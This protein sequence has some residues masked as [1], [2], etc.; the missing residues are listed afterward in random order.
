MSRGCKPYYIIQYTISLYLMLLTNSINS[1]G[2]SKTGFEIKG[3]ITNAEGKTIFIAPTAQAIAIDSAI[4]RNGTFTLK[5]N[6]KEPAYFALLL[7][8]QQA[9]TWFILSKAKLVFTGN[10]DSMRQASIT[11]SK[12]LK[13]AQKLRVIIKPYFASQSASFDSAFAAY[14]RGDTATGIKFEELNVAI[15]KSI[16]DSIANFIKEHPNSYISLAQLNELYKIY[17]VEKSKK[18]FIELSP[19]LQKQS[20][21]KQ[22]KYEIFEAGQLTALNKKAIAFEQADTANKAIR[23]SDF[24]GKYILIDFW[25]SWCGPCRAENPNIKEAYLKY[26]TKGFEVLGVS[27]DN[28]KDAWIKA[29]DKDALPWQNVSDLNGFKN[30]AAQLY[31]V[32]ELPTSYLL[33]TNGKIIAK[34]LRGTALLDKLKSLFGY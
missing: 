34:N 3:Q 30:K 18:L 33:D 24:K 6:I 19:S 25:A 22:L 29:I 32:T 8:G 5:G 13:D 23:L 26:Q 12:E 16:N 14:N 15:T 17:G 31:A 1:L 27:L 20:V 28:S 2:Q 10:G 7:E 11:G 4:I 9:Y 21:G